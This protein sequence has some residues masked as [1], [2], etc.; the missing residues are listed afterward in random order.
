MFG[1]VWFGVLTAAAYGL[2]RIFADLGAVMHV[3]A[4]I[5]TVMVANVFLIIIPNQRKV[6]AQV[7]AG[8]TPDP[9]L[10]KQAKQRSVHNNYMTLRCC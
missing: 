1:L 5:G 7:L 2:T 6:V 3:G 4:I 10:G 9:A 8:Q